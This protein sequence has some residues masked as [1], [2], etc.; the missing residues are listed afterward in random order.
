MPNK[1]ISRGHGLY[2]LVISRLSRNEI[3]FNS[4]LS[5]KTRKQN[6]IQPTLGKC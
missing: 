3:F 4:H 1:I 6:G 5:I 2:G